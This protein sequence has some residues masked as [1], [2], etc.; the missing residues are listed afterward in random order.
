MG[1]SKSKVA[2]QTQHAI[3]V[4]DHLTASPQQT[5]KTYLEDKKKLYEIIY[6]YLDDSD[7]NDEYEYQLDYFHDVTEI[8]NEQENKREAIEQFLQIVKSISENHHRTSSFVNKIEN[9]L[10]HYCDQMKQTF[11]NT[12]LFH[13]FESNKLLVHFLLKKEIITISKT[14]YEEMMSKF[15]SNGN[16]N[17]YFFYSE[18]EK[19]SGK[20]LM[21][22][23]KK[24]LLEINENIFEN[25]ENKRQEGENDSYICSLIRQDSVEEF[26]SYMNRNNFS[27]SSKIYHSIFETNSFLIEKKN[28]TLIEYAAFFGSFQIFQYLLMSKIILKP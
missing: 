6:E 10:E 11:T 23:I 3:K 9:I 2:K 24:E 8:L 25:Y 13:I 26:I 21:K 14:I 22:N 19:F 27:L 20:E 15:E 28:T 12:E 18:L 17:C 16:R 7:E 5:I 1:I 4:S